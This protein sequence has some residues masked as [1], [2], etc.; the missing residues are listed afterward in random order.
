MKAVLLAALLCGAVLSAQAQINEKAVAPCERRFTVGLN[1]Y[2]PLAY[3][4]KGRLRGLAVDLVEALQEKT[5]CKYLATEISRPAA[6]EQINKDRVDLLVL[7]VQSTEYESGGQFVPV[8]DSRRELTVLKSSYTKLKTIP[9]YINDE[10]IK[11]AYMISSR[12]VIS[13]EEERRL[14]KSARLIG[15]PTPEEAFKLLQKGRVQAVLFSS[16]LT[17]YYKAK[18]KIQNKVETVIDAE[19][20]VKVGLYLSKRRLNE[21]E[22]ELLQTTAENLKK[23]GSLLRIFKKYMSEEEALRR[24]GS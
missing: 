21:Q 3:R 7:M 18:F 13:E 5:G 9:Q 19:K 20:P 17:S 16:L 11:F 1:N 23:D 4:E 6:I 14:L 24:L 22:K 8:Y 2:E 10:K 12:S 15:V